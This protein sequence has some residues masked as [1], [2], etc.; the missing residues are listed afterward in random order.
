MVDNNA[1]FFNCT[2]VAWTSDSMM[3]RLKAIHFSW[4]CRSCSSVAW[5][6]GLQLVFFFCSRFPIVVVVVLRPG[7]SIAV[8]LIVSVS[9][10]L[11]FFFI[12]HSRYHD[13]L[14]CP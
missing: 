10:R 9:I 12:H 4:W 1:A 13:L 8:Q 3:A 6:T 2:P 11:F 7:V 5:P 14:V